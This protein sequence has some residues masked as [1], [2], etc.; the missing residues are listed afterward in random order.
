MRLFQFLVLILAF[1]NATAIQL[2]VHVNVIDAETR[3]PL[4][5]VNVRYLAPDL[6]VGAVVQTSQSGEVTFGPFPPNTDLILELSKPGYETESNLDFYV[7]WDDLYLTLNLQPEVHTSST[8][9]A[10]FKK[11]NE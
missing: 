3:F 1:F 5:K 10:R 9:Q 4:D 2:T 8:T 11:M 6:N 7:D